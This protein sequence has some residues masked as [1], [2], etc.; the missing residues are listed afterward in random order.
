MPIFTTPDNCRL[1]YT[2]S[3]PDPNL[4]VIAFLNGLAQ[5]TTYWHAQAKFFA[6]D[7]RVLRYDGRAQ[8]SS[9][10]G[11]APLSPARHVADLLALFD[12]LGIDSAS[13]VGLSHGAYIATAFAARH[14]ERVNKLVACN[15]RASRYGDSDIVARWL[16][17]LTGV[18][19]EAYAQDVITAA[20]GQTFRAGHAHLIP[21]MAK[22][23][24]ARNSQ[25]GLALQLEAMQAYPPASGIAMEV[26]V[27]ALVISGGEDEIVPAEDAV[28]LADCMH[29]DSAR[30]QKAGHSLPVE[31]P[32]RF[33]ALVRD[34]LNPIVA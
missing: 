3:E 25:T 21:M 30:I 7:Y 10:I 29:A 13:L 33:N 32:E 4:P 24:A 14:P 28:T 15:L 31:A 22:A 6:D 19:L 34:F 20:T 11:G 1:F 5:T 18:G 26:N 8:G 9:D 23:V 16:R 12:H 27:P 2:F 17:K